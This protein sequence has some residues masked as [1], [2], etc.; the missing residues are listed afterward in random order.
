MVLVVHF[1]QDWLG[2]PIV[3]IEDSTAQEVDEPGPLGVL[4]IVGGYME[5]YPAT[6]VFHILLKSIPFGFCIGVAVEHHH[7]A[8]LF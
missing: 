6:T 7:Y 5:A 3:A 1:N 2:R 4:V 8:I